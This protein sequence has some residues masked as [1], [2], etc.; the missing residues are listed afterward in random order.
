MK[1]GYFG[2]GI[3]NMKTGVNIGTLWR[4]AYSLGASFIFVIGNRYRHQASDTVKAMKHIPLYHYDTFEDFYKAMPKDCRLIGIDNVEGAEDLETYKHP[5]RA[6]YL[7]G[8]ED[9]GMSKK[10]MDTCHDL[11]QFE[12]KHCLNVSVAGSIIMY[13]RQTKQIASKLK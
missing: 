3:E 5:E 6:V 1:R 11:I 10:A 9:H 8:A 12:S 4:S 13:D 7:L 2:I